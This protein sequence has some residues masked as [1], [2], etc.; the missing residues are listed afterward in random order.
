MAKPSQQLGFTLVELMITVAIIGI[1]FSVALPSYKD[2][3][4]NTRIRTAAESIQNGLQKARSEALM[5]NTTVEFNLGANAAWTVK[6]FDTTKCT[7]LKNSSNVVD[8]IVEQRQASDGGSTNIT[9]V[10]VPASKTNV[11]YNNLGIKTATATNTIANQLTQVSVDMNTAVIAAADSRE[12]NVTI[13][14]AG[15]A[16][17]NVRVCDPNASTGDPRKC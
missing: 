9:I 15:G 1:L 13:G 6:C 3:I 2:W 11:T 4:Q 16:G 8:G 5:R 12:L 17:G 7:D 14:V 10:T